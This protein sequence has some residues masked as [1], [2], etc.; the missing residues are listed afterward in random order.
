MENLI[1]EE[2]KFKENTLNVNVF[3]KVKN[4]FENPTILSYQT[5]EEAK[6]CFNVLVE[7]LISKKGC[8]K[9]KSFIN[10]NT[11]IELENDVYHIQLSLYE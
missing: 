2:F 4:K 10:S 5:F 11:Y 8:K 1:I 7:K 6:E 3:N 9:V